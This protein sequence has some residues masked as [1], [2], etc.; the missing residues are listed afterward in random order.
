MI[1]SGFFFFG[2]LFECVCVCVACV[3][4]GVCW[5]LMKSVHSSYTLPP[6]LTTDHF[7]VC[8]LGMS[9]NVENICLATITPSAFILN[10][11]LCG[12]LI[13]PVTNQPLNS[14]HILIFSPQEI[15]KLHGYRATAFDLSPL[16][17]FSW[18]I[19]FFLCF[20]SSPLANRPVVSYTLLEH[21]HYFRFGRLTF[22]ER[23]VLTMNEIKHPKKTKKF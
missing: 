20:S 5:A 18:T 10:G 11:C 14:G 19:F 17:V 23:K 9:L 8:V 4:V 22:G 21:L 12:G 13:S 7:L 2:R 1:R 6:K 16:C 15:N 3:Y